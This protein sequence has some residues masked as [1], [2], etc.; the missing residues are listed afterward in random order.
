MTLTTRQRHIGSRPLTVPSSPCIQGDLRRVRVA[1]PT[2]SPHSARRAEERDA[3]R[4]QPPHP[5]RRSRG[6]RALRSRAAPRDPL[7]RRGAV[8]VRPDAAGP[9]T[10]KRRKARPRRW[11]RG[12]SCA[13]LPARS[14][15]KSPCWSRGACDTQA[16]A[17]CVKLEPG[18]PARLGGPAPAARNLDTTPGRPEPTA[19]GE[20]ND[21]PVAELLAELARQQR[22]VLRYDAGQ[23]AGLQVSGVFPLD[24]PRRRC[25]AFGEHVAGRPALHALVNHRGAALTRR[26]RTV[27]FRSSFVIEKENSLTNKASCSQPVTSGRPR[28]GPPSLPPFPA[29]G[30]GAT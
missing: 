2:Q 29:G 1:L 7:L 8:D 21:R 16:P 28:A 10:W 25:T 24:D 11:A 20:V 4:G 19:T 26:G 30:L 14:A 22:D 23:L 9:F 13:A 15:C 5:Q 6:G 27:P 12:T 18:R 3:R 17:A